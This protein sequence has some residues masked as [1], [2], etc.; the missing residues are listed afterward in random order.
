VDQIATG[1]GA[2]SSTCAGHQRAAHAPAPVASFS[3]GTG[4]TVIPGGLRIHPVSVTSS[5]RH[6]IALSPCF[7]MPNA[8][9]AHDSWCQERIGPAALS[10]AAA[11]G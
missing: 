6:L 2:W 4:L 7:P 5:A 3:A 8:L 1:N 9:Q 11:W 10:L